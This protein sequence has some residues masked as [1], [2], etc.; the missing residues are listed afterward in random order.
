MRIKDRAGFTFVELLIACAIIVIICT[1]VVVMMISVSVNIGVLENAAGIINQGRTNIELISK[2][3]RQASHVLTSYG[4]Y[5]TS[6]N[7]LI[8][9]VASIGTNGDIIDP[10]TLFDVIVY[11]Q[12]STYPY[13][14][15][16]IVY[17]GSA[18]SRTSGS[19]AYP[20]NIKTLYFSWNGTGLGSVTDESYVDIV[21]IRIVTSATVLGVET[22]I[23]LMT[24]ATLRNS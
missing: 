16:R 11:V 20:G 6:D 19:A 21:T 4:S 22:T 18:S 12:A 14:L 2:D 23:D 15:T 1:A 9:Q 7:V 17:A 5:T 3:I 24:N 13:T 8:L 10:K